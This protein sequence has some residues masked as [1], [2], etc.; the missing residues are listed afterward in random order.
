MIIK[1]IHKGLRY[2]INHSGHILGAENIN[3]KNLDG[4][5]EPADIHLDLVTLTQVDQEARSE[6][7]KILRLDSDYIWSSID[8][9]HIVRIINT[10]T[11]SAF[12]VFKSPFNIR[13]ESGVLILTTQN[14]VFTIRE[15]NTP[16]LFTMVVTWIGSDTRTPCYERFLETVDTSYNFTFQT[17]TP[18][19]FTHIV[20]MW[21]KKVK[22][23]TKLLIERADE[24]K[25]HF[26]LKAVL[27][28]IDKPPK[29][30]RYG[31][32]AN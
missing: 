28:E 4:S 7:K 1:V 11:N 8:P 12:L 26:E 18:E 5:F 13:T 16:E 2:Y 9:E 3:K 31:K 22:D 24:V 30:M 27:S 6:F 15:S 17:L 21:F 25:K 19:L 23:K 29:G 20:N 32:R 10:V 14:F